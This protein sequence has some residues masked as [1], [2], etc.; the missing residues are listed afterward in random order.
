MRNWLTPGWEKFRHVKSKTATVNYYEI[1]NLFLTD[2][3]KCGSVCESVDCF[4][5]PR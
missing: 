2:Q 1:K 4:L 3:S 5:L